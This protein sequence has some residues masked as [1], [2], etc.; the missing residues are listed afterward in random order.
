MVHHLARHRAGIAKV[1]TVC[2][3]VQT[4][5]EQRKHVFAGDAAHVGREVVIFAELGFQNA[6][7]TTDFLLLTKLN[8]V[9]ALLLSALSVHSRRGV[10]LAYRTFLGKATIALEEKLDAF[11]AALPA[12]GTG[13]SCHLLFPP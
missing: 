4:A 9:L 13:I 2:H 1:E 7:R 10:A 6:I 12:D 8:A 11:S 5:L 3:V